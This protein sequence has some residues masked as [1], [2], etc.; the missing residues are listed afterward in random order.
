L[1]P[2]SQGISIIVIRLP[3]YLFWVVVG[4]IA[5]SCKPYSVTD[6]LPELTWTQ[7]TDATDNLPESFVVYEGTD[8]K[9]PIHAWYARLRPASPEIRVMIVPAQTESGREIVSDFAKRENACL[10]VN[11]GY[12][13]NRDDRSYPIGLLVTNSSIINEASHRIVRD[14]VRYDAI[15]SALGFFPDGSADFA[16]VSSRNDSVFSWLRPIENHRNDPAPMP[17]RSSAS[18]WPVEFAVSAGPSLFQHS[19]D[20]VTAEEEIFFYL[21][22]PN[23]HPRT[24]AGITVDGSLILMVVD[25]RQSQSRGVSLAELA[26]MMRSVGAVRAINLDGGGSSA[27][28]LNSRLLNRPLGDSVEREVVSAIV[29]KCES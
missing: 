25:G 6:A 26:Y 29:V 22:I 17:N 14:E 15:R 21:P 28:V 13:L 12:F 1:R 10:A 20:S 16:W 18:H 3:I 2:D 19:A 27:M 4:F 7:I 9:A 11:G 24:A 23:L 8:K 5:G